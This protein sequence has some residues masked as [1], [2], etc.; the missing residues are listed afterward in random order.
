MGANTPYFPPSYV[1]PSGSREPTLLNQLENDWYSGQLAAAQEP[2]LYSE[3]L[4]PHIAGRMTVRFTWLR[5]FHPP[6]VVRLEIAGQDVRLIAKQLSGAGGYEAGTIAKRIDRPLTV[7]EGVR[8]RA[9][10]ARTHV[11]AL[12]ATEGGLGA[13]GA[14]W[15]FEG[16][17]E[18]GY[19]FVHRWSPKN[20]DVRDL[21][22]VLLR[23]TG[24]RFGDVY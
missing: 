8:V 7:R 2:S 19:H 14:Q 1:G 20:G 3:S 10:L 18:R 24:W 23:L 16:V 22:M 5:T 4:N 21:G 9:A 11:F 13:D 17:D 12:P 15:L 6:V